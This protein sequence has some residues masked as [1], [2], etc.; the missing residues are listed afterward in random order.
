MEHEDESSTSCELYFN[1]SVSHADNR[2]RISVEFRYQL[3][4]STAGTIVNY[5]LLDQS[6][7]SIPNVG[8][9]FSRQLIRNLSRSRKFVETALNR[10]GYRACPLI[11]VKDLVSFTGNTNNVA[12]LVLRSIL[13]VSELFINRASCERWLQNSWWYIGWVKANFKYRSTELSVRI[14]L[15]LHFSGSSRHATARDSVLFAMAEIRGICNT[16]IGV[17]AD[18]AQTALSPSSA[19]WSGNLGN[20]LGNQQNSEL[21]TSCK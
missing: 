13:E 12:R 1:E 15:D 20:K 4:L 7:S 14:S 17:Y 5:Q 19:N 21:F 9:S 16:Y 2:R 18:S 8:Q 6:N 11:R 3:P 10:V